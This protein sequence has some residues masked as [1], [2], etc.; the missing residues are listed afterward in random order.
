MEEGKKAGQGKEEQGEVVR[1]V[2]VGKGPPQK[3]RVAH[4]I[5]LKKKQ[6]K[7]MKTS[8]RKTGN[9]KTKKTEKRGNTIKN[10]HI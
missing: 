7:N 9:I 8:K 6:E 1:A 2:D 3:K 10:T 5:Q 4:K